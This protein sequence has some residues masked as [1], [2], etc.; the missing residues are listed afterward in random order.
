[1][2][3]NAAPV[4]PKPCGEVWSTVDR[5]GCGPSYFIVMRSIN[6]AAFS[7]WPQRAVF[8]DSRQK[9]SAYYQKKKKN[10]GFWLQCNVVQQYV[11]A[12]AVWSWP[13]RAA[14]S[15]A[16]ATTSNADASGIQELHSLS[17]IVSYLYH[18]EPWNSLSQVVVAVW[19]GK[20]KIFRFVRYSSRCCRFK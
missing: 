3:I 10:L 4:W 12:S 8:I 16:A 6:A 20:L 5:H 13:C 19:T 14:P 2:V 7:W 9:K 18:R 17:T 1:M 11:N 15:H